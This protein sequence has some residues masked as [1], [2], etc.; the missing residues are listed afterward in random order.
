MLK[1]LVCLATIVAIVISS[2]L[3]EGD[4]DIG[5]LAK[6]IEALQNEVKDLK[7]RVT[8]CEKASGNYYIIK[9]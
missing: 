7:D 4:I 3:H 1:T 9:D 6:Q 8:V 2:K 5:T